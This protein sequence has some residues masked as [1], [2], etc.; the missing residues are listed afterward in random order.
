M[1]QLLGRVRR[2]RITKVAVTFFVLVVFVAGGTQVTGTGPLAF[3]SQL[4]SAAPV[5]RLSMAMRL[6]G[7][8]PMFVNCPPA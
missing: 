5:A 4:G 1:K 6:R 2:R 8:P 3:V 7:R